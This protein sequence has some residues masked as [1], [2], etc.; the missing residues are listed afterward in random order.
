MTSPEDLLIV[1]DEL[2]ET[3][4]TQP[5]VNSVDDEA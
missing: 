4:G 1:E 3:L 5:S 2:V